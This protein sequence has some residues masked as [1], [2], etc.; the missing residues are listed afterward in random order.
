MT[1]DWFSRE[2]TVVGGA[3]GWAPLIEG[4]HLEEAAAYLDEHPGTVAL[5]VDHPLLPRLAYVLAQRDRTEEAMAVAASLRVLGLDVDDPGDHEQVQVVADRVGARIWSSWFEQRTDEAAI[6]AARHLLGTDP[7]FPL[8]PIRL[9]T[10]RLS[11]AAGL[12][13][14]PQIGDPVVIDEVSDQLGSLRSQAA[15]LGNRRLEASALSRLALMKVPE[16]DLGVAGRLASET[17]VRCNQLSAAERSARSGQYWVFLANTV[18]QWVA[19]FQGI[20]GEVGGLARL[21]ESLPHF[22]FDA[23]A[24]TVAGTTIAADHAQM[25][26]MRHARGLLDSLIT[27]RRFANLGVWRLRPLMTDGYLAV[28]SGDETRARERVIDLTRAGAPAE[29]LL[30][31]ANEFAAHGDITAALT[32]LSGVTGERVRSRGL[33]FP[34]SCALEAML[35]EMVGE[36]ALADRSIRYALAAT[37]TYGARRLFAMHDISA[38]IS[39]LERA[40]ADRPRDQW[41]REVLD[42]LGGEPA[43]GNRVAPSTIRVVPSTQ[44]FGDVLALEAADGAGSSSSSPLTERERQVLALV[45]AGASQ[46]QMARELYVS[47]NTVKTHL[48]SIRRKLGVERTVEA[49]ALARSAG[50][51]DP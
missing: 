35:L 26:R 28:A 7:G 24:C 1:G 36:P 39:V 20:S 8:D 25:G 19:H 15:L 17:L 23:V 21:E 32:A 49:A 44:Q 40:V 34:A 16:G 13:W 22:A 41:A 3:S 46:A 4:P 5:P 27:D 11:L 10:L 31:R 12:I 14:S 50:W 33:T 30:I 45:N 43:G 29:A 51:L 48:R 6:A 42:Y 38:M 9:S 47:L 2:D 37:E 18:Q